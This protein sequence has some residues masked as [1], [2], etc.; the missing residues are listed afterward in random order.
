MEY[1]RFRLFTKRKKPPKVTSLPPTSP[2]L[3][4]HILRAHLQVMF[5]KAAENV[6]PPDE[7][8]DITSFGWKYQDG[9]PAPVLSKADPAPPVLLDVVQCQCRAANKRCGTEA[10]G[11]HKEHM[12]CTVYCNC[13]GDVACCNPYTKKRDEDNGNT[14][15]AAIEE[16]DET[17]MEDEYEEDVDLDMDDEDDEIQMDFVDDDYLDDAIDHVNAADVKYSTYWCQV[18]MNLNHHCADL[19]LKHKYHD[20]LEYV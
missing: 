8:A 13:S 1:A 11:C 19:I 3:L 16:Q 9:I 6:A 20:I 14:V 18:D 17:D 5:W 15:G 2:N 7:S 12:S 10:C 4:Q